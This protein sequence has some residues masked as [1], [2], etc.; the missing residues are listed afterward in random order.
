MEMPVPAWPPSNT[1]CGLSRPAREAADAA[2]LAQRREAGLAPG[3]QLVGVR[4]VAG[5]PHDVVGRAVQQPVERHGQLHDPERAAQVAARLGDGADDG[6]A[7]LVAQLRQLLAPRAPAGPAGPGSPEG[8]PTRHSC[9]AGGSPRRAPWS[10]ALRPRRPAS[11]GRRDAS[12]ACPRRV[13]A[14]VRSRPRGAGR[15]PERPP[16]PS[17]RRWTRSSAEVSDRAQWAWSATPRSYSSMESSSGEAA[18]LQPAHDG[19]ELRERL[20]EG[21]R[22]DRRVQGARLSLLTVMAPSLARARRGRPASPRGQAHIERHPRRRRG[23]RRGRSRPMR[24]AHDRVPPVERRERAQ[25]AQGRPRSSRGPC[26]ARARRPWSTSG[27]RSSSRWS[28]PASAAR[29]AVI[30]RVARSSSSPARSRSAAR[31]AD[32]RNASR[33]RR[34]A[35]SCAARPQRSAR[36]VVQSDRRRVRRRRVE[37]HARRHAQLRGHRRRG[38]PDVRRELGERDVGLVADANHD[39]HRERG[40][41]AHHDL[42]VERP[43]VLHRAAAAGE[44]DH[45]RARARSSGVRPAA[46]PPERRHDALRAP[47]VPGPG[48]R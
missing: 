19:L 6:L 4:L 46:H 40:H 5:V 16:A 36:R 18:G 14:D 39:G 28:R 35:S 27:S 21:H 31:Y 10:S 8:W 2:Q 34:S 3:Q 22:R 32:G 33:A 42:L 20:V 44:D 41:R 29:R 43:E 47:R 9:A 1:S 15:A 45:V 11:G 38:C 12:A 25:R 17:T 13:R 7:E 26:V 23:R 30:A 48:R 37:V 24:V